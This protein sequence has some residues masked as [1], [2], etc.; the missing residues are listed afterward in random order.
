MSR[1]GE[2]SGSPQAVDV[3]IEI[4]VFR[5]AKEGIDADIAFAGPQ[6]VLDIAVFKGRSGIYLV[7]LT[8]SVISSCVSPEDVICD[9]WIT[10][11]D[12]HAAASVGVISK[13]G[14]IQYQRIWLIFT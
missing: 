8:K 12:I 5:V 9:Y 10:V 2:S 6:G 14:V 1:Q 7:Y 3:T 4:A 13:N 11:N